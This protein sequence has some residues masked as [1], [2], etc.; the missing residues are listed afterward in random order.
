M[1][2]SKRGSLLS[3]ETLKIVVALVCI[4]LLVSLLT[5]IYNN[6][7]KNKELEMAKATLEGFTQSVSSKQSSFDVF[8]PTSSITK[9]FY[10]VVWDSS[11]LKIPASC[12]NLGWKN[13]VCLCK[14]S[15]GF[16]IVNSLGKV[17]PVFRSDILENLREECSEWTCLN[18]PQNISFI[19]IFEE[20]DKSPTSFDIDY[21]SDDF[22]GV[23]K[24]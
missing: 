3:E 13:C 15:S 16:N 19:S 23:Y 1:L 4:V 7:N 24:K 5:G 9:K 17:I 21:S 2:L 12:E 20:L 10:L 6:Y 22:V 11:A 14:T 18:N 8:N